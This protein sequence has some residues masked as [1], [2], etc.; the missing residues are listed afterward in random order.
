VQTGIGP[1]SV[2]IPKVRSKNGQ[3]V[4]FRSALVPPYVR[5]TRTLEAALPWLY[6]K[7]VSSGEMGAALKV[8]LGPDAKGLSANTV[9]RL[10]RDWAK[11]Y[12]GWREAP[13]DEEP[14][15]YIW[16]DGVYR[17]ER[18]IAR[19]RFSIVQSQA[20]MMALAG[21]VALIGLILVN[22][23]LFF[24]LEVRVSARRNDGR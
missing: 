4:T 17:T 8:L 24:V 5:R 13:L 10:K 6:L 15:V 1:V 21:I 12:D 23:S 11:E 18:L 2:R 16:A 22:L 14:W 7:G 9:S 3:P 20:I 19:R